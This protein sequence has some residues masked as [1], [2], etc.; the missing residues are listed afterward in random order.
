MPAVCWLNG[1]HRS[2]TKKFCS[3]DRRS[4][5][6]GNAYDSLNEYGIRIHHYG[7]H[8]FH[9]NSE[10]VVSYLSQ[11]TEWHPYEHRVRSLVNGL[12]V[13]M[14]INRSTVNQLLG[15]L[16]QTDKE[17]EQFFEHEKETIAEIR[18]SEDFV[19]SKVGRRLYELL[20]RG[21]YAETLGKRAVA[22]FA[23]GMRKAACT[24]RIWKIATSMTG[25]KRCR[26]KVTPQCFQR[27]SR[28]KI[29]ILS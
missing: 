25:F 1:L 22:S 14:P 20:Y 16:F 8:L 5:I 2:A 18:N 3:I 29:S 7:P 26:C 21:I 24:D 4:H 6:G 19:V 9:T 28:A 11:F 10:K 27:W 15:Q 13:P 17:V 12:L 23:V